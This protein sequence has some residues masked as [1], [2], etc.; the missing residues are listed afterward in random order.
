MKKPYI[1]INKLAE[2][3]TANPIRRRQIIT[4]LKKDSDFIKVRYYEVRNIIVPFFKSEYDSSILDA[5]IKKNE[6]KVKDTTWT[7]SD[8]PNSI[9]ALNN[10]KSAE[11]P[12]L[13]TDRQMRINPIQVITGSFKKSA[14][15]DFK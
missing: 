12:D 4:A 7:D 2:Y 9:L 1:S 3:M 10:L 15:R 6:E 13:S 11:L 8:D 5:T 14:V